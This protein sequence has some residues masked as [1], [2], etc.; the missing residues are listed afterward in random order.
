[1]VLNQE[2]RQFRTLLPKSWTSFKDEAIPWCDTGFDV[3]KKAYSFYPGGYDP[4]EVPEFYVFQN[5]KSHEIH[6]LRGSSKQDNG[7]PRFDERMRVGPFPSSYVH[8]EV[9]HQSGKF[10]INGSGDNL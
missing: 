10:E 8:V 6:W 3:Q 2:N 7:Y 9:R 4:E 1:V 5:Y